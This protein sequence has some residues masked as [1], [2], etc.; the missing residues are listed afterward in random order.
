M[1]SGPPSS[2]NTFL[3]LYEIFKKVDLMHQIGSSNYNSTMRMDVFMKLSEYGIFDEFHE[4]TADNFMALLVPQ[5]IQRPSDITQPNVI[6]PSPNKRVKFI[7]NSSSLASAIENDSSINDISTINTMSDF[8]DQFSSIRA[9]IRQACAESPGNSSSYV[10]SHHGRN[11][12][13]RSTRRLQVKKSPNIEVSELRIIFFLIPS[14]RVPKDTEKQF[15][16]IEKKIVLRIRSIRDGVVHMQAVTSFSNILGGIILKN[17]RLRSLGETTPGKY[18]EG[19]VPDVKQISSN[20]PN[21]TPLTDDLCR[22]LEGDC[23]FRLVYCAGSTSK[24]QTMPYP[25]S[26]LFT[27]DLGALLD[28]PSSRN[29]LTLV[30]KVIMT[31]SDTRAVVDAPVTYTPS[32][33]PPSQRT[34]SLSDTL[35]IGDYVHVYRSH[36][37]GEIEYG[38]FIRAKVDQVQFDGGKIVSVD[39]TF[40]PDGKE[41]SSFQGQSSNISID[42]IHRN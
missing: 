30:V 29:G 19:F 17:T 42:C 4:V 11:S 24:F 16:E 18:L 14:I 33:L 22:F 36:K 31:I 8:S 35:N 13:G 40:F 41:D 2:H 15:R 26:A 20:N 3:S 21:L 23:I 38:K 1:D 28:S 34:S 5:H 9:N 25:K 10:H 39:V 6:T 7:N 32:G 27:D 37:D 12:T